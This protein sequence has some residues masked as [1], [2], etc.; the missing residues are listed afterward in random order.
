MTWKSRIEHIKVPN[1]V[2]V[3]LIGKLLS[4]AIYNTY[5]IGRICTVGDENLRS[6][7]L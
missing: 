4:I 5:S 7:C 3:L 2:R 6:T 1:S